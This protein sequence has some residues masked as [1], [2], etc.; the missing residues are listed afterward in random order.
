MTDKQLIESLTASAL[1]GLLA[2]PSCPVRYQPE[3]G[4]ALGKLHISDMA[5]AALAIA[6]ATTAVL[7]ERE[8]R[9]VKDE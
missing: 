4:W 5:E 1:Q 3:Y 2:N 8:A 6:E 9:A 7:C